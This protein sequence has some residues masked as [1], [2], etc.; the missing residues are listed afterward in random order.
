MTRSRAQDKNNIPIS[1]FCSMINTTIQNNEN[2]DK[3]FDA[4]SAK[5][6]ATNKTV[7]GEASKQ[8]KPS[9]METTAIQQDIHN[10]A[11]AVNK[12]TSNATLNK[13]NNDKC[14]F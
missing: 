7:I 1:L 8:Q 13:S 10:S 4:T 6:I 14:L 5:K 9:R 2:V 11:E 12:T 3:M